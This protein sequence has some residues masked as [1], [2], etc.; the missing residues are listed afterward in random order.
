MSIHRSPQSEYCNCLG[1]NSSWRDL[2]MTGL[3]PMLWRLQASVPLTQLLRLRASSGILEDI[4]SYQKV[5]AMCQ[6]L[7][8]MLSTYYLLSSQDPYIRYGWYWWRPS[9]VHRLGN[10][11][12]KRLSHC[13]CRAAVY[14]VSRSHVFF[15]ILIFPLYFDINCLVWESKK[16]LHT[17]MAKHMESTSISTLQVTLKATGWSL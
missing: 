11:G 14:F 15:L 13:L 4:Y 1:C 8:L 17:L 16:I 6:S 9:P 5:F 7:F 2:A 10:R 3:C 12:S